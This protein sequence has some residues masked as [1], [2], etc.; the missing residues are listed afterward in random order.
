MKVIPNFLEQETFNNIKKCILNDAFPW[1]FS[2]TTGHDGD[3]SDFLFSHYLYRDDKQC[4]QFFNHVLMPLISRLNF[5]H[6]IRAKINL[7]TKKP[8]Q[9]KTDF[10]VDL[11]DK[12]T[13]ALFSLNTNN[14]Y[15]LFKNGKKIPSVENQMLIFDGSLSHSSVSPTDTS[16]RVNINMDLI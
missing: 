6:L 15:T 5:N 13:V 1:Y 11:Y 3:F 7:Y 9:I 2:P 10:H 4:S 8:K 14:G 16:I 12:H